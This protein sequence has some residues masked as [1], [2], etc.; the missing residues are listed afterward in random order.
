MKV[1]IEASPIAFGYE[2]PLAETGIT[3]VIKNLLVKID[4][5]CS[6][7]ETIFLF[8]QENLWCQFLKNDDYTKVLEILEY[9]GKMFLKIIFNIL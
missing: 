5:Y 1:V 9:I 2:N 3:R 6:E 4:D 7:N 8:S